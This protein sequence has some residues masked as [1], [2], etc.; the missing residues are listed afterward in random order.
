MKDPRTETPLSDCQASHLN[1]INTNDIVLGGKGEGQMVG[2]VPVG[3]GSDGCR[4]AEECM[5][6]CQVG[7]GV[8]GVWGGGGVEPDA[9]SV[10]ASSCSFSTHDACMDGWV[11]CRPVDVYVDT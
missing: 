5:L 11:N 9:E 7:R 3:D 2:V 6:Q 1:G 8:L 10:R 4:D